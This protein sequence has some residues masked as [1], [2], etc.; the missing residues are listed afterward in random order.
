[1]SKRGCR[2][3]DDELEEA[4]EDVERDQE[5]DYKEGG[6]IREAGEEGDGHGGRESMRM[7]LLPF[8]IMRFEEQCRWG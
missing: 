8:G 7:W 2:L 5:K 1:M 6:G 4:V 3:A